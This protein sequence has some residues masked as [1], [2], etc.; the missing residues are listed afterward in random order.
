MNKLL[1]QNDI[2]GKIAAP[3]GAPTDLGVFIG[4]GI[5]IFLYIAMFFLL[6]YMLWGGLDWISSGGEKEKIAK[7]QGKIT[8]AVIGIIVVIAALTIFT[9]IAGNVLNIITITP[10]GGW[11]LNLPKLSP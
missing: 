5:R 3:K 2:F 10:G 8:N 6:M 9:V 7:A 4:G 1:A 11:Q